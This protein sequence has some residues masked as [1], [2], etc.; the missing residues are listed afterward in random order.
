M[1]LSIVSPDTDASANTEAVT[2]G[3]T[4]SFEVAL[5]PAIGSAAALDGLT[6][7]FLQDGNFLGTGTVNSSGVATLNTTAVLG[8]AR[9]ITAVFA[10]NTEFSPQTS[11]SVNV[12]VS[13]VATQVKLTSTPNPSR[14][15]QLVTFR[16]EVIPAAGSPAP[17]AGDKVYFYRAGTILLGTGTLNSAGVATLPFSTLADGPHNIT[18]KY[19]LVAPNN[20]NPTFIGSTSPILVQRVGRPTVTTLAAST[21]TPSVGAPIVFTATVRP[22]TGAGIPTGTV[23]FFVNNVAVGTRALNTLGQAALSYIPTVEGTISVKAVYNGSVVFTP[24]TSAI[25]TRTVLRS[26]RRS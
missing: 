3:D 11:N 14:R 26:R 15:G 18:A 17:M 8:G 9:T 21:L 12:N 4:V 19:D 5:T 6:V 22:A 23:T 10:G 20:T 16:A 1:V 13:P 2:Y 7:T 24:S 25:L